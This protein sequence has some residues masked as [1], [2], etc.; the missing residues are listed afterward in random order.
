MVWSED[1]WI[2]RLSSLPL[3]WV[4]KEKG[5]YGAWGLGFTDAK[6]RQSPR[7]NEKSTMRC[8]F[9]EPV[10]GNL[11][12]ESSQSPTFS[13]GVDSRTSSNLPRA[14]ANSCSRGLYRYAPAISLERCICACPL[15]SSGWTHKPRGL[16]LS[17]EPRVVKRWEQF[18]MAE[19][20]DIETRETLQEH[21]SLFDTTSNQGCSVRTMAPWYCTYKI[22]YNRSCILLH[23]EASHHISRLLIITSPPRLALV[24]QCNIEKYR[25]ALPVPAA[26]QPSH[27]SR[28]T[29]ASHAD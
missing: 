13:D 5:R 27:P 4:V 1:G 11:I 22:F 24:R 8:K 3:E 18:A 14:G 6:T 23:H 2:D 12:K 29:F 28:Y 21:A 15:I 7:S 17:S 9:G 20:V 26:T 25:M 16:V 10:G 19:V